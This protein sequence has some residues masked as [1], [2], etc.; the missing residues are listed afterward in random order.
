MF[1]QINNCTDYSGAKEA[2]NNV[3]RNSFSDVIKK[4]NWA[5][6]YERRLH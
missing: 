6:L 4:L 3:C 2:G 5:P 1:E